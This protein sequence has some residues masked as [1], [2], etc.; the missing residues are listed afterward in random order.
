VNDAIANGGLSDVDP[1][2]RREDADA[3]ATG[4]SW[5]AAGEP[6]DKSRERGPSCEIIFTTGERLT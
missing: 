1:S 4:R 3:F 2:E 5:P 6:L